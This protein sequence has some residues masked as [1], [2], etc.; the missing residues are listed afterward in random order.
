MALLDGLN[1][2]AVMN[3]ASAAFEMRARLMQTPE[4]RE[5]IA[6]EIERMR[7]EAREKGEATCH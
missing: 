1:P 7:R 2:S 3:M 6:Q 4:G 5:M